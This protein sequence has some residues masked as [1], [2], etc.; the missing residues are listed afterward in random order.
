MIKKMAAFACVLGL[1]YACSPAAPTGVQSPAS[2]GHAQKGG[3]QKGAA[4]KGSHQHVGGHASHDRAK[5][6]DKG[7]SYEDV[8]C[9]AEDEGL[10]WCDSATEIAFCSGGEWWVLDCAHPDID[11][12]FCGD[13]GDTVDC[14]VAADF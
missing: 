13:N 7:A 6:S 9:D 2:G 14:Y 8:G 11:G 12:D 1:I 5:G 3:G 4:A 10:A